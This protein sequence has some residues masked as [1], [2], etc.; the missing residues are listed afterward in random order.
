MT[1]RVLYFDCFSG[2]AGDMTLAALLDLGAD[3]EGLRAAL[4]KL[5]IDGW[6]MDVQVERRDGLRGIDV[7]IWV[8]GE[9]EGN[10]G[11]RDGNSESHIDI[12]MGYQC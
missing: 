9:K 12:D 4:E 11:R 3:Q 8:G 10:S 5:P 2:I 6:S 1:D 7:Q